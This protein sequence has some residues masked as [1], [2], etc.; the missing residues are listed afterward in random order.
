MREVE[1][2]DKPARCDDQAKFSLLMRLSQSASSFIVGVCEFA[3]VQ[4]MGESAK[5]RCGLWPTFIAAVVTLNG[6]CDD[7]FGPH[8]DAAGSRAVTSCPELL[9]MKTIA[10]SISLPQLRSRS[11]LT[12]RLAISPHS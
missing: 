8:R 11:C 7:S 6:A 9:T 1:R 5:I 4:W 10:I 12:E 2:E 3:L